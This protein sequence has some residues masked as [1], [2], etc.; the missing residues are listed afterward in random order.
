MYDKKI[1]GN[2]CVCTLLIIYYPVICPLST[3]P[4]WF[5]FFVPGVQMAAA[6]KVVKT[7]CDQRGFSYF[8]FRF[9]SIP[10]DNFTLKSSIRSAQGNS[11]KNYLGYRFSRHILLIY[12]YYSRF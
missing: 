3:P 2:A 6:E 10:G 7:L 11:T 4:S 1:G 8:F 5:V 9:V 12:T